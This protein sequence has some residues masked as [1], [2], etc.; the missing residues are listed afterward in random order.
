MRRPKLAVLDVTVRFPVITGGASVWSRRGLL[1][2][3]G[4]LV[5]RLNG[6]RSRRERECRSD[7]GPGKIEDVQFH[8]NAPIDSGLFRRRG[9]P[10]VSSRSVRGERS[11]TA[12]VR[13]PKC[14]VVF[15]FN[16]GP[17]IPN[18]CA[19]MSSR[20]WRTTSQVRV[21]TVG[22]TKIAHLDDAVAALSLEVSS[23]EI[24]RLEAITLG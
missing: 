23:G 9:R 16:E 22:A 13:C 1:S 2:T 14:V 15:S 8:F 5:I 19:L 11:V 6:Y 21:G 12:L 20:R 10:V 7:Q 24:D 18:R 4:C 3:G 17:Y